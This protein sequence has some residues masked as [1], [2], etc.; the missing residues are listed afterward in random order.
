MALPFS[1]VT[2]HTSLGYFLST[3]PLIAGT[4]GVAKP[5]P[6]EN[7]NYDRCLDR[8]CRKSGAVESSLG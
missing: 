6:Q 2:N 7:W 1:D 4:A 5:E 8:I 3:F